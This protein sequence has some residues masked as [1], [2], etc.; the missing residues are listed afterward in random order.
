[1]R[2]KHRLLREAGN[3]QIRIKC[4]EGDDG[5]ATGFGTAMLLMGF[6]GFYASI[7]SFGSPYLSSCCK[8]W[9]V[10]GQQY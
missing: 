3:W 7:G 1:M 2:L 6:K 10:E 5:L 4:K 8:L 9:S